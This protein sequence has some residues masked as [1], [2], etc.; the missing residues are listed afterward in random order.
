MVPRIVLAGGAADVHKDPYC[1]LQWNV[2]SSM[3][4]AH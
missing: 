3:E 1:L 2:Q 4:S